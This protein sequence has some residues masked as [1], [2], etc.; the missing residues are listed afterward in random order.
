GEKPIANRH[1]QDYDTA[2][3]YGYIAPASDDDYGILVGYGT[4]AESFEDYVLVVSICYW[5]FTV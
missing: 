1:D 4:A 3:F 5:F 2:L